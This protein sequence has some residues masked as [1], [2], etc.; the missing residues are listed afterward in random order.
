MR[1]LS[2]KSRKSS[3]SGAPA[4]S[5]VT[6]TPES[7][8]T[9]IN[10]DKHAGS[11]NN[12]SNSLSSLSKWKSDVSSV[13]EHGV[14]HLDET[15]G[16][17]L[18]SSSTTT[19]ANTGKRSFFGRRK[20]HTRSLSAGAQST[21]DDVEQA[22]Q[23]RQHASTSLS[24]HPLRQ[25]TLPAA[26]DDSTPQKSKR[27]GLSLPKRGFSTADIRSSNGEA[28]PRKSTG[29]IPYYTSSSL[30]H[31][32]ETT[33]SGPAS[34]SSDSFQ[35]RSFRSVTSVR[36]E[37]T[38]SSLVNE[39]LTHSPLSTRPSSPVT[40]PVNSIGATSYFEARPS[41]P[42]GSARTPNTPSASIP[43]SRFREAKSAKTASSPN[44]LAS[45]GL[46]PTKP[47]GLKLDLPPKISLDYPQRPSLDAS[48]SDQPASSAQAPPT[49]Q[50]ESLSRATS[51]SPS[52]ES[53]T[54]ALHTSTASPS[55]LASPILIQRSAS[56]SLYVPE[57]RPQSPAI[58]PLASHP[59]AALPLP[60]VPVDPEQQQ[61]QHRRTHS[62]INPYPPY[63]PRWEVG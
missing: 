31:A 22:S 21:L 46:G 24:G 30:G 41:S 9:F 60:P 8:D 6:S 19:T 57:E 50:S 26:L 32:S 33:D 3:S 18:L 20:S 7:D 52:K 13:D 15:G 61:R 53:Y 25:Q 42:S 36:E 34:R 56:P 63:Q 43:V 55:R 47:T 14:L 17:S 29:S 54:T 12:N 45:Q 1:F 10:G 23:S 4:Q 11:N 37:P 28:G 35:L 48:Q 27:P 62:L 39:E 2:L 40:A 49:A 51:A 58:H 44:G 38:L 59:D 5:T 16:V